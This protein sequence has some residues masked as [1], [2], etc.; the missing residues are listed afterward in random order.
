MIARA[1]IAVLV[2]QQTDRY[3]TDIWIYIWIFGWKL[4]TAVFD[5]LFRE[6]VSKVSIH[7]YHR[8]VLGTLGTLGTLHVESTRLVARRVDFVG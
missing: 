5:P 7:Q 2:S 1:M 6:R 8:K 3:H 4:T